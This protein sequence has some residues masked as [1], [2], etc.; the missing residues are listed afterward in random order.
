MSINWLS[1]LLLIVLYFLPVLLS[2]VV[3]TWP[4]RWRWDKRSR[5][6]AA[7]S[8][9][10]LPT[11]HLPALLVVSAKLQRF[12]KN[13]TG[14]FQASA[15]TMVVRCGTITAPNGTWSPA[16]KSFEYWISGKNRWMGSWRLNFELWVQWF[17]QH[18]SNL[19][20]R[21]IRK[22]LLLFFLLVQKDHFK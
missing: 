2:D 6:Q 19:S 17:D 10:L 16:T 21:Q 5:R 11:I 22:L 13:Q 12:L 14:Q 3:C 1:I 7:S 4:T 18:R 9:S 15:E 8:V 20:F